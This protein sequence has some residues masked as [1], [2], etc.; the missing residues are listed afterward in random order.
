MKSQLLGEMDGVSSVDENGTRVQV[1]LIGATNCP[2][3]IDDAIRRRL[4]KRVYVPLPDKEG[5]KRLFELKCKGSGKI[6]GED[7]DYDKLGELTEGYSGSDINAICAT[8]LTAPG[9]QYLRQLTDEEKK[10]PEAVDKKLMS[11][12]IE[13]KHFVKEIQNCRPSVPAS[14]LPEYEKFMKD[15]GAL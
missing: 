1:T 3:Q 12:P 6:I 4:E 5:R 14:K 15:F 2:E 9:N 11:L 8:A 13:M 10:N 7:V